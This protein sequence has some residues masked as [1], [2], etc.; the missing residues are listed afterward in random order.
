MVLGGCNEFHPSWPF[1][2]Q[3]RVIHRSTRIHC[4]H[5]WEPRRERR[6]PA[7]KAKLY[8]T[9]P[10]PVGTYHLVNKFFNFSLSGRVFLSLP[11]AFV[12][13]GR[14]FPKPFQV[15]PILASGQ[16]PS[17][18]LGQEN[19]NLILKDFYIPNTYNILLVLF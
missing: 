19:N 17:L 8:D 3:T 10:G 14:V 7:T 1:L 13:F 6:R 9:D 2:L 16:R 4:I 5:S 11:R 18:N 12:H 15:L